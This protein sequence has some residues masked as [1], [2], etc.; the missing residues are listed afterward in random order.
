MLVTHKK[1]QTRKYSRA[2][3]ER[4]RETRDARLSYI[5]KFV[6][7]CGSMMGRGSLSEVTSEFMS[8]L[9]SGGYD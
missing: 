5:H 6:C 8:P 3:A 7:V 1:K 4:E 2:A 9:S